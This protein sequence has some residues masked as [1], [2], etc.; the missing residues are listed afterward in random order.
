MNTL[1]I[2]RLKFFSG[3]AP[4]FG[5]EDS[6]ICALACCKG[7]MRRAI[8]TKYFGDGDITNGK[9]IADH[10]VWILGLAGVD[11]CKSTPEIKFPLQPLY[12]MKVTN[13][14]ARTF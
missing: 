7:K 6:P 1:Y 13:I 4:N 10:D 9:D 3:F 14:H 8:K 12:L 5:T 2:Y 11:L